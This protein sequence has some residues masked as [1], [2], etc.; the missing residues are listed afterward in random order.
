MEAADEKLLL[1]EKANSHKN[2]Q[3]PFPV[4]EEYFSVTFFEKE[5]DAFLFYEK[6][7]GSL[8]KSYR[9]LLL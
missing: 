3:S 6:H 4:F 9:I 2:K 5:T 7:I 8:N 1:L